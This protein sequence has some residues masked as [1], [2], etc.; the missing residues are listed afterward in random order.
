MH[1]IKF[2]G[3]ELNPFLSLVKSG[4]RL[5]TTNKYELARYD[6]EGIKIVA[7]NSGKVV[8]SAMPS[9]NFRSS[10]ISVLES[11][12]QFSGPTIGADEAGKGELLGPLVA[13][14]VL[15]KNKRE[16]ALARFYGAMDSKELSS[17]RINL[18]YTLLSSFSHSTR[19]LSPS[20]FNKL[21]DNNLSTLLFN[22]HLSSIT[23][24][25]KKIPDEKC[26]VIIDKFGSRKL[27]GE[28]ERRILEINRNAT[29]VIEI[30]AEKF[31]S[32]SCASIFARHAYIQWL[33]S[34]SRSCNISLTS[35]SKSAISAH[36]NRSD[37][38]KLKYLK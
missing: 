13:C 19:I 4:I 12:D 31:P 2:N 33:L 18:L 35:L 37:F 20:D 9:G 1:S 28:L 32:V 27:D 16:R 10:I 5:D 8:F 11:H 26:T 38:C 14:A 21:F 30:R 25:L 29:A 36:P 3:N 17:S 22:L 24:L 34:Y 6:Y 7:Y 15:L 23:H